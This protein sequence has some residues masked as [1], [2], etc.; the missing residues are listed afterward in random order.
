MREG[1][2]GR[3]DEKTISH[4]EVKSHEWQQRFRWWT[5]GCRGSSCICRQE[6]CCQRMGHCS[7]QEVPADGNGKGIEDDNN[8]GNKESKADED[9]GDEGNDGNFL[10]GGGRG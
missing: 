6:A 5:R 2:F 7:G 3:F 10:K 1:H 9:K 8:K 4:N